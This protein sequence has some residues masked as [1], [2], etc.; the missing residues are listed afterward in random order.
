MYVVM[1][2]PRLRHWKILM[3]KTKCKFSLDPAK[4]TMKNIFDLHLNKFRNEINEVLQTA[5]KE[6]TIEKVRS[7][8]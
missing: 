5:L 3:E 7:S 1:I 2:L 6:F 4:S 8:E